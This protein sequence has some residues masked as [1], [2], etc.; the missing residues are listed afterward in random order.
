MKKLF[1]FGLAAILALSLASCGSPSNSDV[2]KPSGVSTD[3]PSGTQSQKPDGNVEESQAPE[4]GGV[5]IPESVLV[6]ES[7]IKI[8]AT[9]FDT[10]AMFGPELKLL[11]ENDSGQDLTFQ[12]RG[13]SVNGYMVET[14][15]SVDVVTG[16]KANGGL[17]FSSSDLK[18]CGID[19]IAD[20]EFSFHIFTSEGWETYLDTPPIQLKTS[21]ADTYEYTFDDSGDLAYE[22]NGVKLLIKGLAEDSSIFGPSIVVYLENNSDASITV[23]ARDTSVNGFMLSPV[24]SSEV[25]GGKHAVDTIT[26]MSSEL[27]EN[28]ITSIDTV[29]LS[30]HIFETEGWDTIVDTDAVT[31][32]F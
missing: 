27:E 10:A 23:Q 2:Q 18:P 8:T 20:L 26:F 22:G 31:I 5:S 14:M 12:S 6:D 13:A 25:A 28:N 16:K 24:F 3:A 30:F 15:M 21:A 29:E 1:S 17:S 11:I 19:T 9:G 7:G 32:T 4:R